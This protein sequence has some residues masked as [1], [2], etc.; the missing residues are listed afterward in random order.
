MSCKLFQDI[1]HSC[2]YNYGG[3][4]KIYLLDIHDFLKYKFT[5]DGNFQ[6]CFVQYIYKT[7][8]YIRLDIVNESNFIEN[9]NKGIYTQQ[10]TTFVRGIDYSK[11]KSLLL[12]KNN[13]YLVVFFSNNHIY[14][15]GSDGGASITF[16]QQSG[17]LGE[18]S[19][20]NITISKDSILPLFQV[21]KERFS[22]IL[23]L[24]TEND[25]IILSED[26]QQ[27]FGIYYGL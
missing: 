2:E 8:D 24:G 12:A 20:Y 23:A 9:Y 1:K 22:R 18:V 25:K 17:Q 27:I 13:K 6:S 7:G 3:I 5:D 19:G 11:T 16:N 4:S 15:F 14:T 21:D 10:I 26:N